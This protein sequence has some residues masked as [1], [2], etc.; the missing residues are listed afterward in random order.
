MERFV[1]V[2][3]LAISI[4][5]TQVIDSRSRSAEQRKHFHGSTTERLEVQEQAPPQRF[6]SGNNKD[7]MTS[8]IKTCAIILVTIHTFGAKRLH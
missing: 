2:T 8:D 6:S 3:Q 5:E 7:K 4:R 1:D